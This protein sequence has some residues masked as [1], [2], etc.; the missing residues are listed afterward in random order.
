MS[1]PQ[2][3]PSTHL[4]RERVGTSAIVF[5]VLS[6]A[7][8][9]TVIA[10][11]LPAALAFGGVG[12]AGAIVVAGAVLLLFAAGF[13]AMSSHVRN[14]GAFYAYVSRGIGRP[15]GVGIALVTLV[16]YV[17][18]SL[19]FYGLIGFFGA[20]ATTSLSG[21]EVPWWVFSGVALLAVLALSFRNVDVGARVLAVLVVAESLLII[22]VI[23]G[24]VSAGT[25]DGLSLAPLDPAAVF[26]APGAGILFV[27]AFGAF[28]GFEATAVYSEEA[29]NA[30][31]S[32]P[33]A[34][35]IAIAFLTVFYTIAFVA[36][37]NGLGAEGLAAVLESD[38]T[39]L[40]FA[41]AATY[42]GDWVVNV[43]LVLIVTS[44]FAALLAFHNASA[45]YVYSLG[46]DGV[47]WSGFAITRGSTGAPLR[48]SMVLI[49]VAGITIIGAAATGA[50]PY[51]GL[52][53]P[54]YALGVAGLI[55]SQAVAAFAVVGFFRSD[56]RG[57]SAMRV[58]VLP[59]LGAVGLSAAWIVV[60]LNLDVLTGLG[61]QVNTLLVLPTP[62]LLV[63]GIIWA[64][65]I[66]ARRPQT[67]ADLA[68]DDSPSAGTP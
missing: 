35:Y 3:S 11:S 40:P 66:R 43:M 23:V 41:V 52:A 44:F 10:G 18:I 56:R 28:L 61:P 7:A 45:R 8:P 21:V 22:A 5:F 16:S 17:T 12:A 19:S 63:V 51:T 34:T 60:V 26:L 47:I 32:I 53:I 42:L 62:I 37:T 24:M 46:R 15:A 38:F 1:Q 29:K 57:H 65:V 54:T 9:L 31:R 64:L 6:A 59:T 25:P 13:T 33:R 55:F 2:S 50:D 68:D 49:A 58:V 48:A 14:S 4:A 67:Y 39:A 27:F 20:I 36:F 30:S